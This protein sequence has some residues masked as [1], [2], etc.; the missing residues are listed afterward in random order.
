MERYHLFSHISE[1]TSSYPF[2]YFKKYNFR[3]QK[4]Y[5]YYFYMT[6]SPFGTDNIANIERKVVRSCFKETGCKSEESK[7]LL[8]TENN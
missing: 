3:L 5:P 6:K 8:E 2:I 1:N 7:C 4:N